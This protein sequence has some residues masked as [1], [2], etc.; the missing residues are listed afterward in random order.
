MKILALEFSSQRR[1]VAI[2]EGDRVLGLAEAEGLTPGPFAL[3]EAA[4]REA[5][6]EREQ[7]EGIVAGLGPGS[8]TGVRSAIATAQGWQLALGVKL[9]GV[10][11]AEVLAATARATGL[12]GR[13]AVVIDALRGEFYSASYEVTADGCRETNPLRL[14]TLTALEAL[15]ATGEQPVCPDAKCT[16]AGVTRLLPSA[17]EV[18]RLAATRSD[19][20]PGEKLEPIYLRETT[21]VKAPPPRHY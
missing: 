20:Q 11:S 7:I 14:L 1:G 21:F 6:L 5:G 15:I 16:F 19:F 13:V 18:G 12:R 10:S 17:A 4:L 3:I 8:Y 9:L 2:V